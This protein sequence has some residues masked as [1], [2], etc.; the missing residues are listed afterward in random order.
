MHKVSHRVIADHLRS[1]A[2][3]LRTVFRRRMKG[4]V[5]YYVELYDELCAMLGRVPLNRIC[6]NT[7]VLKPDGGYLS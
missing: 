6:G 7:L 1:A 2:F 5:M 3:L 4:A